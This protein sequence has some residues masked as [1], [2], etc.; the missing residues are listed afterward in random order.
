NFQVWCAFQGL[1]RQIQTDIAILV[2]P[3]VNKQE[4]N[5][6]HVQDGQRLVPSGRRK[7]LVALLAKVR[8]GQHANVLLVLHYQYRPHS[9]RPK[10]PIVAAI[11]TKAALEGEPGCRR[12]RGGKSVASDRGSFLESRRR[13]LSPWPSPGHG[14]D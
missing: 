2:K 10:D 3:N 6:R 4:I 8:L 13:A 12:D 5:V 9:Y 1:F 14:L 11:Y 7:G